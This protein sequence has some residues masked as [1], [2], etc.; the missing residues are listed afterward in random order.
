MGG[1]HMRSTPLYL[2]RF[3]SPTTYGT[4]T[5]YTTYT[6][7]TASAAMAN[8]RAAKP[9]ALEMWTALRDEISSSTDPEPLLAMQFGVTV[10]KSLAERIK[11]NDLS[12]AMVI[13]DDVMTRFQDEANTYTRVEMFTMLTRMRI[14]AADWSDMRVWVSMHGRVDIAEWKS[15][16]EANVRQLKKM[17]QQPSHKDETFARLA[18]APV[19]LLRH[20]PEIFM[21]DSESER[22]MLIRKMQAIIDRRRETCPEDPAAAFVQDVLDELRLIH[23]GQNTSLHLEKPTS[24]ETEQT[25]SAADAEAQILQAEDGMDSAGGV[26]NAVEVIYGEAMMEITVLTDTDFLMTKAIEP[27]GG[28]EVTMTPAIDHIYDRG[29]QRSEATGGGTPGDQDQARDTGLETSIGGAKER[30]NTGPKKRA[31][32]TNTARNWVTLDP[33]HRP[34]WTHAKLAKVLKENKQNARHRAAPYFCNVKGYLR[35]E[36]IQEVLTMKTASGELYITEKQAAG[37]FDAS[38]NSYKYYTDPSFKL[39]HNAKGELRERSLHKFYQPRTATGQYKT[40][41]Y[42][43]DLLTPIGEADFVTKALQWKVYGDAPT[44]LRMHTKRLEQEETLK[45]FA[46]AKARHVLEI[47]NLRKETQRWKRRKTGD[48]TGGAEQKNAD[49]ADGREVGASWAQMEKAMQDHI[50]SLTQRVA[51][52]QEQNDKLTADSRKPRERRAQSEPAGA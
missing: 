12:E 4:R 25:H 31:R 18:M 16:E 46:D 33:G 5:R 11:P 45:Q 3:C 13:A 21:T 38:K 7:Y 48:T 50:N 27:T 8:T 15:C 47:D 23:A 22:G 34:K 2:L 41:V 42:H 40:P 29:V 49:S 26:H 20:R 32:R 35:S 39:K 1:L 43:K 30:E 36:V 6:H 10:R 9:T 52:L 28:V 17:I 37:M 19:V 24:T 44:R 14:M 51:E